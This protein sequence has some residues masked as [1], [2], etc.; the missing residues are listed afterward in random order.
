MNTTTERDTMYSW[1]RNYANAANKSNQLNYSLVTRT[2]KTGDTHTV[3]P[4]GWLRKGRCVVTVAGANLRLNGG[5]SE[6]PDKHRNVVSKDAN[7][8]ST[9]TLRAG[10]VI[11]TIYAYASTATRPIQR[12][13]IV[14]RVISTV[15]GIVLSPGLRASQ[16]RTYWNIVQ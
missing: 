8:L 4:A 12:C 13:P 14:G 3:G 10:Y 16:S 11:R 1:I 2:V 6:L 7:G 5:A 9:I 15:R